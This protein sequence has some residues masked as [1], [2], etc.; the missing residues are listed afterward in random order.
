[1][2]LQK[3]QEKVAGKVSVCVSLQNGFADQ[4]ADSLVFQSADCGGWPGALFVQLN[5]RQARA[6]RATSHPTLASVPP[7]TQERALCVETV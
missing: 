3:R 2:P 1:M 5:C 6:W 4:V 7:L